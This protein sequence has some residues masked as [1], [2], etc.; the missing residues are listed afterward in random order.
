[1]YSRIMHVPDDTK[2]SFQA[3]RFDT[4]VGSATHKQL[5]RLRSGVTISKTRSTIQDGIF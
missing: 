2:I 5:E 1:M 3:L 4:C